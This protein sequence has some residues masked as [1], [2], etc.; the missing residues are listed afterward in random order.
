ME[1][2]KLKLSISGAS[3]KTIS[4]IEQAK[5][6]SKN[7]VVIEKRT[8][9]FGGKP[10]FSRGAKSLENKLQ[11]T[12]NEVAPIVNDITTKMVPN[13]VPN[14]NPPTIQIGLPKPKSNTHIIVKKIN[15]VANISKFFS[16][17]FTKNS[18][19][20]LMKL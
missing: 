11:N 10:N 14:I 13:H 7:T 16:F 15:I 2:K 3:K 6:H 8:S 19:L 5:S 18:L 4:S 12:Y 20:S 1:K 17:N 9:R